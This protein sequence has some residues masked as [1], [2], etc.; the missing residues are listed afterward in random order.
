MTVSSPILETERLHLRM[1][2]HRDFE[3]YTAIHTDPDVMRPKR[4]A[5][6]SIMHATR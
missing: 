1:L 5:D 2:E 3:E 6:V 4:R